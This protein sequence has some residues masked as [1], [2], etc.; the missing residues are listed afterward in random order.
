[1]RFRAA[2]V[3]GSRRP[4][5]ADSGAYCG[6]EVPPQPS[7]RKESSRTVR[8]D[9]DQDE[10]VSV[11]VSGRSDAGKPFAPGSTICVW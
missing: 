9:M 4:L 7:G 5:V 3:I 6:T 1:V 2:G 10:A 11:M 8:L